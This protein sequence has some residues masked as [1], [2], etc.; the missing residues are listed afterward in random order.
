[1]KINTFVFEEINQ[2]AKEHIIL[3]SSNILFAI[4]FFW[5][6]QVFFAAGFVKFCNAFGPLLDIEAFFVYKF[7]TPSKDESVDLQ[8]QKSKKEEIGIT[9]VFVSLIFWFLGGFLDLF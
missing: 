3:Y 1:M 9:L 7:L 5:F 2:D 6:T 4:G 8:Q